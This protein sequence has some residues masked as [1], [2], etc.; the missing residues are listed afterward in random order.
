M[1]LTST[2]Q[3]YQLRDRRALLASDRETFIEIYVAEQRAKVSA[4]FTDL[5]REIPSERVA[6]FFQW[7]DTE[8]RKPH[9]EMAAQIFDAMFSLQESQ[10]RNGIT[11]T[12]HRSYSGMPYSKHIRVYRGSR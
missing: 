2:G 9:A 4:T 10:I 11:V 12:R 3:F 6:E 8:G 7:F 1:D 5:A